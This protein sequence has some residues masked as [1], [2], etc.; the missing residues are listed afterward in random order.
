MDHH[1]WEIPQHHQLHRL[2]FEKPGY[3]QQLNLQ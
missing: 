3:L 1:H 2:D